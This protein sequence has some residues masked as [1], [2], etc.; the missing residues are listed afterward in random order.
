MSVVVLTTT[1]QLC[2]CHLGLRGIKLEVTF[3]HLGHQCGS[4]ILSLTV[5][6]AEAKQA[7]GLHQQ[8]VGIT[9]VGHVVVTRTEVSRYNLVLDQSPTLHGVATRVVDAV[10]LTGIVEWLAIEVDQ[11]AIDRILLTTSPGILQS[12]VALLI[13]VEELGEYDATASSPAREVP[14]GTASIVDPEVGHKVTASILVLKH[15]S[16]D[17][18]GRFADVFLEVVEV[19][20]CQCKLPGIDDDVQRVDTLLVVCLIF[21]IREE[22]VMVQVE[23]GQLHIGNILVHLSEGH[24]L[25]QLF[26][27]IKQFALNPLE[28]NFWS[29]LLR[30]PAIWMYEGG[31]ERDVAEQVKQIVVIHGTICTYFC[32]LRRI[33]LN[34]FIGKST[35]ARIHSTIVVLPVDDKVSDTSIKFVLMHGDIEVAPADTNTVRDA[36]Y[37]RTLIHDIGHTEPSPIDIAHTGVSGCNGCFKFRLGELMCLRSHLRV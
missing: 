15:N 34:Q 28:G 16:E 21:C 8:G 1:L 20:G 12:G 36:P 18:L 2:C 4:V 22:C 13:D 30:R 32:C 33:G 6:A 3:T 7:L 31:V 35:V 37:I 27:D 9:I 17:N 26:A 29:S 10:Q 5:I 25:W 23:F 19:I 14:A 11:T 24:L